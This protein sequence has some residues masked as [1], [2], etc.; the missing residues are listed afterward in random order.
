[1][2][3]LECLELKRHGSMKV[4]YVREHPMPHRKDQSADAICF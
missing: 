4:R 2:S 3:Y 1:M